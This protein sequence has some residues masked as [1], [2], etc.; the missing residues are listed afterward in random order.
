MG[1]GGVVERERTTTMGNIDSGE[2]ST[3]YTPDPSRKADSSISRLE[4][5]V[6]VMRRQEAS[7]ESQI[8]RLMQEGKKVHAND[9]ASK[10]RF[11]RGTIKNKEASVMRLRRGVSNHSDAREFANTQKI[12]SELSADKK[13]IIDDIDIGVVTD[14]NIESRV[15]DR[16]LSTIKSTAGITE[17]N[18]E[19]ERAKNDDIINSLMSGIS[20]VTTTTANT[21]RTT[22]T[23]RTNNNNNNYIKSEVERLLDI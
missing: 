5:E 17:E 6:A 15:L 8:V 22:T 7:Y 3:P 16:E 2:E 11:L 4:G 9:V 21:T 23:V 10:L 12:M 14:D 18:E 20:M 13:R 19:E 1:R